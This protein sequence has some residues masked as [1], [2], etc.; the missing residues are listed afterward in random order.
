SYPLVRDEPAVTAATAALGVALPAARP[1][2]LMRRAREA[3][4]AARTLRAA[5]GNV[6]G[7]SLP[8]DSERF[9][10]FLDLAVRDLEELLLAH[11]GAP[12]AAEAT[13]TLGAILDY[14]YFNEF[15]AALETYR[16][17]IVRHPGTAWA[18]K[19]G[20]RVRVLE[21]IIDA[22]KGGPHGAPAPSAP[23]P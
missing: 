21:G 13:Y 4:A 20:E 6:S 19:A 5:R 3:F 18:L 12:E 2:A 17:V 16:L 9:G 23:P 7:F 10:A 11:P 14:P 8:P 15:D 1:A 22:G